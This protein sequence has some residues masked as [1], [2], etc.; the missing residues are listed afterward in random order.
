G[1]HV[2][3][4][5]QWMAEAFL[6]NTGG[7]PKALLPLLGSFVDTS[8]AELRAVAMPALILSGADDHDNGS[9]EALAALMPDASFSEIPGNHMS[10]VTRPELG[11]AMAEFLR[12]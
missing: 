9:A 6:K 5:P 12:A 11:E 3:G 7:D 8:E 1:T 2:R 10:A 4:S